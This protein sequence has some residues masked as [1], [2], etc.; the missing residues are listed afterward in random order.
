MNVFIISLGCDKNRVDSEGIIFQLIENNY[1]IVDSLDEANVV[2]INTCAFIDSAKQESVDVIL[3]VLSVKN[4][5]DIKVIV[6]G[7]LAQRYAEVLSMEFPTI[8]I[9]GIDSYNEIIDAIKRVDRTVIVNR[10]NNLDFSKW[11]K[12]NGMQDGRVLTTPPHYAYLKIADGCSNFCSYCAIPLIRGKYRSYKLED[13]LD[14][15]KALVDSGV[16]EIIIVAQDTTRYGFD[17]YNKYRIVEL[18]EK[19]AELDVWKIRLLYAYPEL[20]SNE[21]VNFIAHNQ[22]MAKYIDMPI[23]HI[24]DNILKLMNRRIDSRGVYEKINMIKSVSKD[25]A[26]RSSFIVGFPGETDKNFD[27]LYNFIKDHYIDFAGF[28]AYSKEEDT[29]ACK[30]N[31][32]VNRNTVKSRVKR[33][34]AVQ[35][36]NIIDSNIGEI[37]KEIELIIDYYDEELNKYVGRTEGFAPDVDIL[38]YI[39]SE[40]VLNVSE[41]YKAKIVDANIDLS[42]RIVGRVRS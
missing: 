8:T 33:L 35:E 25:I 30:M 19:V 22:K 37:G 31:A 18:L 16:K 7:C 27:T 20:V 14:E 39:E 5:E 9:L 3:S 28:F 6:V 32:Q 24:D 13:I 23:Q 42:A 40:Q 10:V 26:I 38:V 17:L 2:I 41:I 34:Y 29:K 36:Q 4:I 15:S 21:L 12:F 11:K 1:T